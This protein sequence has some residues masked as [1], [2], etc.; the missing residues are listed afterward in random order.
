MYWLREGKML[1]RV[2]HDRER[3][4]WIG[5]SSNTQEHRSLQDKAKRLTGGEESFSSKNKEPAITSRLYK[6]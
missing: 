4:L 1:K 5:K 3:E 2:Q 6:S